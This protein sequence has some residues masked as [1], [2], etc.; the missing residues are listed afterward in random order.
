MVLCVLCGGRTLESIFQVK[1]IKEYADDVHHFCVCVH[2]CTCAL[3]RVFMCAYVHGRVCAGAG[4][5]AGGCP[6]RTFAPF[7]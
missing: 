6:C 7:K 5:G 2:V 1:W 3:V 4:A